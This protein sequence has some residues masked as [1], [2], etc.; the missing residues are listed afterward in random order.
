MNNRIR[1]VLGFY[2]DISFEKVLLIK[3]NKPKWQRGKLNGIGGKIEQEE[4]PISAMV[5]EF[6]EEAGIVEYCWNECFKIIDIINGVWEVDVFYSVGN[7]S[8]ARQITNEKLIVCS[9]NN[10]PENVIWNIRWMIPFILD[11]TVDKNII[12]NFNNK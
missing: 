11:K 1:A 5:R 8:L 9:I 3:K 10:L 2:F 7:L 12:F 6:K 4:S